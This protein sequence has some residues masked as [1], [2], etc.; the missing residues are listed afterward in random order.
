MPLLVGEVLFEGVEPVVPGPALVVDPRAQQREL[1][2]LQP[3]GPPGALTSLLDQAAASQHTDVVRD[4]LL[5]QVERF[6]EFS[7]RRVAAGE[8]VHQGAADRV[9]ESGEGGVEVCA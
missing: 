2:D 6:G 3:A 5:G 9:T 4:R 8:A 1:V 7:H